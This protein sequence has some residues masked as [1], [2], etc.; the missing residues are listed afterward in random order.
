VFTNTGLAE[1][2]PKS[3]SVIGHTRH[4]SPYT[5]YSFQAPSQY[6]TMVISAPFGGCC[7]W[8]WYHLGHST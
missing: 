7:Y 2:V 1:K 5:C 8:H 4:P 3:S 6:S